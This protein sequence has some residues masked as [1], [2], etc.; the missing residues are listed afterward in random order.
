MKRTPF[1]RKTPLARGN[2]LKR[3]GRLKPISDRRAGRTDDRRAAVAEAFSGP[4]GNRCALAYRGNCMGP[5]NGHELIG[6]Y[7]FSEGI[8]MPENILPMCD[9]HNGWVEDN[10][11]E[12]TLIGVRIPGANKPTDT[13]FRFFALRRS[14]AERMW[15]QLPVYAET[16]IGPRA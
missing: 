12:A 3:T 5:I 13:V 6:R 2:G 15:P 7:A 11:Y 16:E 1:R 4:D 8:Y 14:R 9:M 10:P